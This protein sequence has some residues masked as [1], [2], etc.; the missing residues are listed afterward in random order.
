MDPQQFHTYTQG[1]D[2]ISQEN[3]QASQLKAQR[4]EQSKLTDTLI[5]QTVFCD[6]SSAAATRTWLDDISLA[7]SRVGQ[8]IEIASS[9]VTGSLRKELENFL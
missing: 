9:T 1:L 5:R 7:F 6:G 8:L 4:V 3:K 2:R